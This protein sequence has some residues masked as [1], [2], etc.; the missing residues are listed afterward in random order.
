MF[1]G[2]DREVLEEC[3]RKYPCDDQSSLIELISQWL[4]RKDPLPSWSELADVVENVLLEGELASAIRMTY[5]LEHS[6]VDKGNVY[7][8]I[9]H[10]F[11][12]TLFVFAGI[13][14]QESE[15]RRIDREI[16]HES[17]GFG[18][19]L[20]SVAE[21]LGSNSFS[22]L[23]HF[24]LNLKCPDGSNFVGIDSLYSSKT[25]PDL[26]KSLV[27][28]GLCTPWDLDVLIHVVTGLKRQDILALISSYVPSVSIGNPVVIEDVKKE[29]LV[30]AVSM[31]VAIKTLDLGIV[32]AV[33]HDLCTCFSIQD[34]PFLM[35]YTGWK[36][37]P[38]TLFFKLP[39][40]CM[41][42]VERGLHCKL[43]KEL[44]EVGIQNIKL[45]IN[46]IFITI[47]V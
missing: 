1:L 46:T 10:Y 3:C 40:V 34:R 6:I 36:S 7:Q 2:V 15:F 22:E 12:L 33:K 13:L 45:H 41:S 11:T 39:I 17:E 18:E 27:R 19:L 8:N 24:L 9:L 30:M 47:Q 29:E 14:K 21:R 35:Q 32:S 26:L 4:K 43:V 5:C 42:I 31:H 23:Q 44:K 16:D 25:V 28:S 38:V 37:S 20:A